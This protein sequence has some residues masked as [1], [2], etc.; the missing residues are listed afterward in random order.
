MFADATVHVHLGDCRCTEDKCSRAFVL[1][2]YSWVLDRRGL[3]QTS[4]MIILNFYRNQDSSD[5][6]SFMGNCT[7][8][9]HVQQVRNFYLFCSFYHNSFDHQS[10]QVIVWKPMVNSLYP[11][12]YNSVTLFCFRD[13]LRSIGMIHANV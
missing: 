13:V 1:H 10:R 11:F 12:F 9:L 5:E 3:G 4:R 6:V 2:W 8:I 7:L